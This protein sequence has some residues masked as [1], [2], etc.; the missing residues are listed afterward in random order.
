ME[1]MFCNCKKLISLDLSNFK[2]S[3]VNNSKWMF[4]NCESLE[5]LDLSNFKIKSVTEISNMFKNCHSLKKLNLSSFDTSQIKNMSFLFCNFSLLISIDISNFN[6][7]NVIDMSYMFYNCSSLISIDLSSF[8]TSNVI[9][10][11]SMFCFCKSLLSI[12]ISFLNIS[13]LLNIQKM[14]YNSENLNYINFKNL[15]KNANNIIIENFIDG[16]PDNL[17]YCFNNISLD[18]LK[19]KA[20]PIFD[21]SHNWRT[22]Q[23]KL[24]KSKRLCFEDCKGDETNKFVFE[25]ICYENVCPTGS[26]ELF[27]FKYYCAKDNIICPKNKPYELIRMKE[28][29]PECSITDFFNEICRPNYNYLNSKEDI[30]KNTINKIKNDDTDL[31]ISTIKYDKLDLLVRNDEILYQVT[32]FENQ[33]N[34]KY[35][36]ISTLNFHISC[37]KKL[38]EKYNIPEN[39]TIIILKIDYKIP[40]LYIPIIEYKLFHPI[41]KIELDLNHCI[42]NNYNEVN[43]SIIVNINENNLYKHEPNS[44]YYNDICDINLNKESIDL[45]IYGRRKEYNNKYLSLC[46]KNCIYHGY[47]SNTKKVLCQCKFKTKFSFLSELNNAKDELLNNFVDIKS[48]MNLIVLKCYNLLFNRDSLIN[49]IGSYTILSIAFIYIIGIIL[50]LKKGYPYLEMQIREIIKIK[51]EMDNDINLNDIKEKS[52]INERTRKLVK[53]GKNKKKSINSINKNLHINKFDSQTPKV[54][55]KIKLNLADNKDLLIKSKDTN[56]I[57]FKKIYEISNQDEFKNNILKYTDSE[58]NGLNYETA[59][60]NDKRTYIQFYLS[61][62]KTK[63]LL[64]FTFYPVKDHN[65][66]IIKICLFFFSFGLYFTINALFFTDETMYKIYEDHGMFNIIIQMPHILYSTIISVIIGNILKTLSLSEKNINELK[67]IEKPCEYSK[68]MNKLIKCL[69]IKF[70]LFFILSFIFLGL[71]WYYLSSFCAVYKNT[72]LFLFKDTI[73]MFYNFIIISSCNKFIAWY[74]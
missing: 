43:I 18:K 3:L 12:D 62:L 72:Q 47:D 52:K 35:D 9:N 49:N 33:K 4:Y 20:C 55:S 68:K 22:V 2:D 74:F 58:I 31:F 6:T 51:K 29:I 53:F 57:I 26:Y 40:E 45:T 64:I 73:I 10:M 34:N 41:S 54:N 63:H 17:V 39:E 14:F 38:K 23:K 1:N 37:E 56:D 59:L 24:V 71:F 25:N 32:S 30:I 42:N 65:S 11:S 67:Y 28:C 66:M 50:F 69:N 7:K 21:C 13:S 60:K 5:L 44:K 48:I 15:D 36:D 19:E 16:T 61:L 46:E 8:D 70:Y 27:S